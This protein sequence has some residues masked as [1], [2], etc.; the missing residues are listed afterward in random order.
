MEFRTEMYTEK[1]VR[2][3]MNK[4]GVD[5]SQVEFKCGWDSAYVNENRVTI[6]YPE[7]SVTYKNVNGTYAFPTER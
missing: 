1:E 4:L 3:Y 5:G 7:K 6:H 2:A